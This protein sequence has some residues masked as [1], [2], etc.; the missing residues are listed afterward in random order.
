MSRIFLVGS[1]A[2]AILVVSAPNAKQVMA[3]ASVLVVLIVDAYSIQEIA[4]D[5]TIIVC[6]RSASNQLRVFAPVP[7]FLTRLSVQ[8]HTWR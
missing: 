7:E 8:S 2:A 1:G 4:W 6:G 3:C 5:G